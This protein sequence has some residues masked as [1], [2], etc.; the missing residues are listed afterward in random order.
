MGSS[1]IFETR[2]WYSKKLESK[3]ERKEV[4]KN[5]YFLNFIAFF[6]SNKVKEC[7]HHFKEPWNSGLRSFILLLC[8]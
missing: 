3:T 1:C 8:K 6:F 4:Q 7:I 5:G 2:E